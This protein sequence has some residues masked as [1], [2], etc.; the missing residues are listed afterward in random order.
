VLPYHSTPVFEIRRHRAVE[1]AGVRLLVK[2][3]DLNHPAVSG[4]KWWKL[5]YNLAAALET[6]ERR[7]VTFG[8]AFSNHIYAVAA[9]TRE[10][11]L[12]AVGLIRGEETLP[13]NA[14]LQYA[15][16]QGMRIH[17]L[18]RAQYREKSS[19]NFLEEL[20]H[21][22]GNF[23]LIPEGGSNR[24]A[25]KGCAEFAHTVLSP[26]EFQYLFL[27]VGTGGTLAGLVCGLRDT[28][29]VVGVSVL[30]GGEFLKDDVLKMIGDFSGK[31]YSNWSL[32][33][34]YHH[35]GYAKTTPELLLFIREMKELY[36]LPL[37]RVYTGKMLWGVMRE[38]E[39]GSFSRGST[40][41]VLHTGGLQTAGM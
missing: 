14:T 28:K 19:P 24:L 4:N 20:R 8:G 7:V 26:I 15:L 5:K 11:H 9:A 35:G 13:P 31:R 23:Y 32:L 27:P 12:K 39:R 2:R 33:T 37:D 1:K 34:E 16:E 36:Q 40:I 3:E 22:F 25:V 29:E 21:Q 38:I 10:L 6:V 41:V 17:Y 18:T 30:K